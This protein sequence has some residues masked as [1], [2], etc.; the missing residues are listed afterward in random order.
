MRSGGG[1]DRPDLVVGGGDE[2]QGGGA[3]GWSQAGGEVEMAG[4]GYLW[5]SIKKQWSALGD[6]GGGVVAKGR[7]QDGELGGVEGGSSR[8]GGDG[9][10]VA[11]GWVQSDL[12][13]GA[14]P[15]AV[16][17]GGGAAAPNEDSDRIWGPTE[18]VLWRGSTG[19]HGVKIRVRV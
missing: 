14:R 15:K 4:G 7:R 16:A 5:R 3:R 12:E 13:I 19:H 11:G 17:D 10:V 18:V 9:H 2:A 6:D 1:S 8:G